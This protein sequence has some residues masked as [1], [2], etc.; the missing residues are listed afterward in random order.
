[1]TLSGRSDRA[2]F[3]SRPASSFL[4]IR[5]RA[6]STNRAPCCRLRR[7]PRCAP[8]RNSWTS[9]KRCGP[10]ASPDAMVPN[11]TRSANRLTTAVSR[12]ASV[13]WSKPNNFRMTS[14]LLLQDFI[15]EPTCRDLI[16][17]YDAWA[18]RANSFD[19]AGNP[20]VDYADLERSWVGGAMQLYF[21]AM[22]LREEIYRTYKPGEIFLESAF[23]TRLK[24]GDAIPMHFDSVEPTPYRAFSAVLY[25]N[26]C[27]GGR[28]HITE[29][30]A[31]V[32][33]SRVVV[34]PKP[35]LVVCFPSTPE[36]EHWV[37]PV[38]EGYRYAAPI[39]FTKD[40]AWKAPHGGGYK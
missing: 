5:G 24:P 31:V 11:A 40:P 3:S 13:S 36:Y 21:I 17:V 1:M 20:V 18:P 4:S 28:F 8:K 6:R 2:G 27:A 32:S 25:L 19:Y 10:R 14:V 22:K 23:L 26:A 39:W 35:G 15:D 12:K 9:L 16:G 30:K 7:R 29:P 33:A 38:S 34:L 37:T